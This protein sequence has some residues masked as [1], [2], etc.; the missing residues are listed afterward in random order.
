MQFFICF[1]FF[2]FLLGR[3]AAGV[4]SNIEGPGNEREWGA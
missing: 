4:K 3:D 2:Y 1:H